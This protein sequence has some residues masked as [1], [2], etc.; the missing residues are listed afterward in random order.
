MPDTTFTTHIHS[1]S[2]STPLPLFLRGSVPLGLALAVF[3]ESRCLL[4]LSLFALKKRYTTG[5]SHGQTIFRKETKKVFIFHTSIH[6]HTLRH[7]IFSTFMY[8]HPI[9]LLFCPFICYQR[10]ETSMSLFF[11]FPMPPSNVYPACLCLCA[12]HPVYCRCVLS[13]LFLSAFNG[14]CVFI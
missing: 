1:S 5:H 14:M 6:T 13:L 10:L 4:F 11:R 2:R 7:T 9:L 3:S 12:H 8:Y